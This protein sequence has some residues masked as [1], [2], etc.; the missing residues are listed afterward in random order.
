MDECQHM[1]RFS[2][3]NEYQDGMWIDG[4]FFARKR[5]SSR[6]QTKEEALYGFEESDSDDD[7]SS[8]NKRRRDVMKKG[9]LTMPVNFVSTGKVMP[10]EEI[11]RNE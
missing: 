2:M 11:D 7:D 10:S 6:R 5:K 1:E 3:E 9:D 4:E 8:A